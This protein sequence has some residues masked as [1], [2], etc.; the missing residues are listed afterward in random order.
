[1]II[2]EVNGGLGNQL[3]QY[4]MYEKLKSLGKEAKLDLSWYS[5][6]EKKQSSTANSTSSIRARNLV[7]LSMYLLRFFQWHGRW[8]RATGQHTA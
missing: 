6:R 7:S 8:G 5:R 2:V 3:Q 1:M 4:A